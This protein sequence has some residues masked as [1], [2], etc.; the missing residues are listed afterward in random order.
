MHNLARQLV[1]TACVFASAFTIAGSTNPKLLGTAEAAPVSGEP[2]GPLVAGAPCDGPGCT[3]LAVADAMCD[4]KATGGIALNVEACKVAG[5]PAYVPEPEDL[6]Y[7]PAWMSGLRKLDFPF[8]GYPR[9]E[10]YIHYWTAST[11]GRRI[12]RTWLRR[13]GK[14][15]AEV[16]KALAARKLP[17]DLAGLVFVESGFSPTAKS[18]AGAVGLWQLMPATAKEYGLII[19]KDYDERRSVSKSSEA[20]VDHLASLY[21]KLGSWELVLAAYDMGARALYK[22][23]QSF[24]ATDFWA[25]QEIDGALPKETAKYV[26]QILAFS[27]VLKNLDRFGYDTLKLEQPVSTSDLD[28]PAGVPL[29]L[30]A[31]AAGTSLSRIRELNPEFL[32]DFVPDAATVVHIPAGGLARARV[33][34]PHLLFDGE[35][36]GDKDQPEYDWGVENGGPAAAPA[37]PRSGKDKGDVVRKKKNAVKDGDVGD[38]K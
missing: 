34:L 30:V 16:D 27:L 31:Q 35:D 6:D 28:V 9:I 4:P 22:K 25:L 7:E 14:Y 36:S 32:R 2:A 21:G 15:R 1:A 19:S 18:K 37:N 12:F 23:Q 33:L 20:A 11:E 3:P 17:A 24:E 10:R 8:K 13:S 29:S 38:E 26:P 5:A